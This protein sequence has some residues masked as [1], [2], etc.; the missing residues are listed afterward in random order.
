MAIEK[1]EKV[2]NN[3][4]KI[5]GIIDRET[6][7]NYQEQI[8]TQDFVV[9]PYKVVI[10]VKVFS[11]FF[12]IALNERFKRAKKVVRDICYNCDKKMRA[13][14]HDPCWNCPWRW[15]MNEIIGKT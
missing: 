13:G 11:T 5:F 4:W 15:V 1:W 8:R 3:C 9:L 14:F 7:T 2:C 10:E 12:P 6:G